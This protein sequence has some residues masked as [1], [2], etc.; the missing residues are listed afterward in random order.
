MNLKIA[1]FEGQNILLLVFFGGGG[2][3]QRCVAICVGQ[4]FGQTQNHACALAFENS[5]A[6]GGIA[7]ATLWLPR[8]I[9]LRRFPFQAALIGLIIC[10]MGFFGRASDLAIK[11]DR[12]VKDWGNLIHG[13][14]GM[15][16]RVDSVCFA[17]PVFFMWCVIFQTVRFAG[18]L[19]PIR[20][21]R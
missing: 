6:V 15:L 19:I 3:G 10:I 5:G 1:G 17:A 7:S 20:K 21:I 9:R 14:G 18:R 12:G 13:H 8:S 2:A 11:R 16:D 4:A